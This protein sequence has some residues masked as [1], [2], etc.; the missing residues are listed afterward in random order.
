MGKTAR[1]HFTQDGTILS[2]GYSSDFAGFPYTQPLPA[3][4][5][6]AYPA[7]KYR[8]RFVGSGIE[9]YEVQDWTPPQGATYG[10]DNSIED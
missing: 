10:G 7:G 9:V 6:F 4:F 2:A 3:D 5:L 1:I 8:V